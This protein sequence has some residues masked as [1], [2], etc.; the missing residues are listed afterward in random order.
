MFARLLCV[1]AVSR[2]CKVLV[3]AAVRRISFASSSECGLCFCSD[4][5][6]V[7][8]RHSGLLRDL[9]CIADTMSSV[10]LSRLAFLFC[11]AVCIKAICWAHCA[12]RLVAGGVVFVDLGESCHSLRL[13]CCVLFVFGVLCCACEAIQRWLH[14]SG[15]LVG[16]ARHSMAYVWRL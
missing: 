5:F 1:S 12:C 2:L 9:C 16:N 14:T 13:A 10:G 7:E 15:A 11:L 8:T 3:A 6:C 4:A